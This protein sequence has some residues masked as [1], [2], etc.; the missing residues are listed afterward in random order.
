MSRFG[1]VCDIDLAVIRTRNTKLKGK[2]LGIQAILYTGWYVDPGNQ[3]KVVEIV[4]GAVEGM[5]DFSS[6]YS[7]AYNALNG[8]ELSNSR[9]GGWRVADVKSNLRPSRTEEPN[10]LTYYMYARLDP[11]RQMM[12]ELRFYSQSYALRNYNRSVGKPVAQVWG[13]PPEVAPI[14]RHP[15]D[16]AN[17]N[18]E[19]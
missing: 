16:P 8:G 18:E 5:N 19:M 10:R 11:E 4:P 6:W 2:V 17:K 3:L 14:P 9:F 13:A 15:W 12:I 1:D 7:K